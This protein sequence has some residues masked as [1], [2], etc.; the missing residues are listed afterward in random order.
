MSRF[1]DWRTNGARRKKCAV[2]FLATIVQWRNGARSCLAQE[3]MR[4]W[5]APLVVARAEPAQPNRA[6]GSGEADDHFEKAGKA[7]MAGPRHFDR[8]VQLLTLAAAVVMPM[9]TY[10]WLQDEVRASA[11]KAGSLLA[12]E[13]DQADDD[14]RTVFA[15]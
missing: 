9:V 4:Q 7:T 2:P 3:S 12:E 14:G 1:T 11:V 5:R 15:T 13:R 6:F 10:R 8:A